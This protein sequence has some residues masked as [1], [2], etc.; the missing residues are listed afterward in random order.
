M[1]TFKV[2]D[3]VTVKKG[4]NRYKIIRG[5]FT[6]TKWPVLEDLQGPVTLLRTEEDYPIF[7]HVDGWVWHFGSMKP[8]AGDPKDPQQD[9]KLFGYDKEETKKKKYY[10]QIVDGKPVLF[11]YDT[12]TPVAPK[13]Q[14]FYKVGE[15]PYFYEEERIKKSAAAAADASQSTS[16]S[17]LLEW[18]SRQTNS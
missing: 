16:P 7:R 5:E 6:K 4:A 11:D 10:K 15:S 12:E 8:L 9:P 1:A 18:Q 14:Y 3:L 13:I 2:G 17:A